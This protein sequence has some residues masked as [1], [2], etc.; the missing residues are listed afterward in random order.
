[1][2]S[3]PTTSPP[4]TAAELDRLQ[5]QLGY[6]FSNPA[7]LQQALTHKSYSKDN[8]ERLEFLGDA[9]LGYLIGHRLY[10]LEKQHA[11]DALSLMRANLVRGSSLADVAKRINLAACLRLGTGERKSGGRQ[12][13]SIL[14]DALEAVIGAI[15]EDKNGGIAAC[16]TVVERLFEDRI[17]G[18]D[19]QNLKDAKTRLQ[20]LLQAAALDL[21]EYRVSQIEGADHQR[22][23]TVTCEI[24]VLSIQC[25]ATAS[26]RRRAEQAA[27]ARM[28]T[29]LAD[30][31]ALNGQ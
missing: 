7:L 26:S 3:G 5:R 24:P 30:H 19:P 22:A 25:D 16:R 14:A 29:L 21:P 18:L 13:N 2:S 15:H 17:N 20:E 8:N 10:R 1:M 4:G 9:V 11:E 6:R 31:P 23:Y 28:L 27:A 12:R